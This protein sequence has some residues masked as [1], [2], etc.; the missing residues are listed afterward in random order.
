LDVRHVGEIGLGSASDW[1][2]FAKAIKSASIIVTLDGDFHSLVAVS[3]NHTLSVI[4]LHAVR[5]V[6]RGK[7]V[8]PRRGLA[9]IAR[10][11]LL[12]AAL[13]RCR[14]RGATCDR[15]SCSSAMAL[16]DRGLDRVYSYQLLIDK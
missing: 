16:L 1:S 13:M 7:S 9:P 10:L 4:R 6:A 2:I 3:G 11:R 5:I 15:P 12:R 14:A 8:V